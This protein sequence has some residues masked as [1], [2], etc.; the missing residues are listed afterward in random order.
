MIAVDTNVLVRLLTGDDPQQATRAKALFE[1]ETILLT[2]TVL[3]ETEWV[4]RRLYGFAREQV[5]EALMKLVSLANVRCDDEATVVDAL[6]WAKGGLDFADAMHLASA[7]PAE[8]F[9]TFDV[10][11]AKRAG[12]VSANIPVKQL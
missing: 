12:T 1:A 8:S 5:I 7:R 11:L 3:L 6:L 2:K 4:L 10:D 9:A